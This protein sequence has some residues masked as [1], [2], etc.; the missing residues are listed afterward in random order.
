MAARKRAK[1]LDAKETLTG[2]LRDGILERVRNVPDAWHKLKE[3]D[4]QRQID[5]CTQAAERFVRDAVQLIEARGAAAT[6]AKLTRV[7]VKGDLQLVLAV[8]SSSEIRHE[9][10]D[11]VESTVIVVIANPDEFFGEREETKADPDQRDLDL[12]KEKKSTRKKVAAKKATKKKTV[13]KAAK[14]I[15]V[16]KGDTKIPKVDDDVEFPP[17]DSPAHDPET[18]EVLS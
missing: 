17:G 16:K 7:G 5:L 4:Q 15:A 2:D 18:G 14:K 13:R 9:I 10:V 3:V 1:K 12:G 6:P 8:P 11:A